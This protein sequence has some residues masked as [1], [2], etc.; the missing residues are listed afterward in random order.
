MTNY[1]RARVKGGTYFFTVV[2]QNRRSDLLVRYIHE[3]RESIYRAK[4]LH[5][6]A[7]DAIVILPDH[8]HAILSLP[9]EDD[10]FP[11]RWRL[12]KTA[13]SRHL[14]V[15]ACRRRSQRSKREKGIWQRRYWEHLIRGPEDF[16]AH[17]DYI[18][19]NPVKHGL[20]NATCLWPFSSFHRYVGMGIYERN[21]GIANVK[22]SES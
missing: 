3:L 5:P 7:I 18:H 16:A 1:R 9:A 10:D 12:I 2:L 13:F 15:S 19:F 11:L 4:Q 22:G 14:P 20:V 6:F 21:W 17:V 8:L